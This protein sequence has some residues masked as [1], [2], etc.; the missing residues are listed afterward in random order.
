VVC[1]SPITL[2]RELNF[3]LGDSNVQHCLV[4]LIQ[5]SFHLYCQA[6]Q[7]FTRKQG[8]KAINRASG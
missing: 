8:E 6:L 5:D 3:V 2:Q 1:G 4:A 7:G